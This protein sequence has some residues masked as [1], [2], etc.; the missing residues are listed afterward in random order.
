MRQKGPGEAGQNECICREE[1]LSSMRERRG[2]VKGVKFSERRRRSRSRWRRKLWVE[3][4][5][6]LPRPRNQD[7]DIFSV[8]KIEVK[9]VHPRD[10][11]C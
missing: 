2:T 8:E 10:G 4:S 5:C 7:R 9:G 1:G 6:L 11:Q 3:R